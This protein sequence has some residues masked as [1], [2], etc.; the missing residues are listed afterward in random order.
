MG[1]HNIPSRLTDGTQWCVGLGYREI[2]KIRSSR[3]P[4]EFLLISS[5]ITLRCAS[6]QQHA[7][8]N[9]IVVEWARKLR[10]IGRRASKGYVLQLINLYKR[11]KRREAYS[12]LQN[13]NPGN[14]GRP[15]QPKTQPQQQPQQQTPSLQ[16]Q[17]QQQEQS[18][19]KQREESQK[20]AYEV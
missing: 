5:E 20:N 15:Q 2:R 14:Q 9:I 3:I 17:P 8:I 11:R 10:N 1:D 19:R 4:R 12:L 7:S 13:R 6:N 16:P 18:T